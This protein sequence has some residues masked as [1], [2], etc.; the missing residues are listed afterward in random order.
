[1]QENKNKLTG[2]KESQIC[3]NSTPDKC[4][5]VASLS[6]FQFILHIIVCCPTIKSIDIP[7]NKITQEATIATTYYK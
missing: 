5:N 3:L 4:Q 2:A 1:M 6:M 7:D